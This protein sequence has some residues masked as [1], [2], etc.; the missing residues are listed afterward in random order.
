MSA[1]AVSRA[2]AVSVAVIAALSVALALPAALRTINAKRQQNDAYTASGRT[3]ASADSLDIDNDFVSAAL[4]TLPEDATYVVLRPPAGEF[5]PITDDALRPYMRY[6]LL[7]RREADLQRA[8]YVLC[9][10]CT[11]RLRRFEPVWTGEGGM[12]I[13]ERR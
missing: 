4:D 1:P 8:Q 11:E 7:P 3:L 9:Y 12:K 6:Q 2:L 10:A 13:L 5:S